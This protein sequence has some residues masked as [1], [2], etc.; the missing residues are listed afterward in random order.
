[1]VFDFTRSLPPS[2]EVPFPAAVRRDPGR[3]TLTLRAPGDA[4]P[5]LRIPLVA[6]GEPVWMRL[7]GAVT[8]VDWGATA[9]IDLRGATQRW[10]VGMWVQ[11]LGSGGVLHRVVEFVGWSDLC[12]AWKSHA[13]SRVDLVP[14]P[15]RFDARW[16]SFSVDGRVGGIVPDGTV[17][18]DPSCRIRPA[19]GEPAEL[20][21]EGLPSWGRHPGLI[22]EWVLDRLDL[23][24]VRLDPDAAPPPDDALA[25]F[26]RGVGTWDPAWLGEA[27]LTAAGRLEPGLVARVRTQ[28]GDDAAAALW[29]DIWEAMARWHADRPEVTTALLDAPASLL[30]GR[31]GPRLAAILD[32]GLWGYLLAKRGDALV[33][34]G[35]EDEAVATW[36]QVAARAGPGAWEGGFVA[37]LRLADRAAARGDAGAEAR[38]L[39]RARSLAPDADLA[40]RLMQ[41]QREGN[42]S[43]GAF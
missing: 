1:V 6:T 7:S 13:S 5:V 3:R 32:P 20:V 10:G 27:R 12:E 35:R 23:H 21:V 9:R 11:G 42:P 38:W 14:A 15:L 29:V 2:T 17:T 39:D 24:G 34:D 25:R 43:Q 18:T 28:A 37:S 41:T 30:R 4:G 26:A 31:A 36:E 22:T 16:G 33:R 8:E 40:E 19:A